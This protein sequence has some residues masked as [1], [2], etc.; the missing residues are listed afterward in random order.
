VAAAAVTLALVALSPTILSTTAGNRLLIAAVNRRISGHLAADH[1]SLGWLSGFTARGLTI[2]DPAGHRV[3]DLPRLDTEVSLL[4]A[5][6]RPTPVGKAYVEVR[7]IDII[8]YP[9]GSS[10]LSRVFGATKAA[11]PARAPRLPFTGDVQFSVARATFAASGG[12][13]VQARNC[14]G[15]VVVAADRLS[16]DMKSLIEAP[17]LEASTLRLH[18][19]ADIDASRGLLVVGE[20]ST[21]EEGQDNRLELAAGT[22]LSWGDEES[23]ATLTLR[24]DLHRL[25]ALLAPV[26]PSTLRV[27]GKHEATLH[28]TG[29]LAEGAGLARLRTLTVAP[30]S[31]AYD[32]IE[33]YGL[34]LSY[35][36]LPVRLARGVLSFGD[37]EL[38]AN[39]GV[40]VLA[41]RIDLNGTEPRYLLEEPRVVVRD[42]DLND[43]L[44]TGPLAFLPVSWGRPAKGAIRGTVTVHLDQASVPLSQ[45]GLMKDGRLAGQLHVAHL[46]ADA[47]AI[48]AMVHALGPVASLAPNVAVRD[49]SMTVPFA[50][51][52]GRV[53][54]DSVAI[55]AAPFKLSFSGSVGL[56]G[57]LVAR[58]MVRVG[59]IATP[60][61]IAITGTVQ[62]PKVALTSGL[63]PGD[64]GKSVEEV[65]GLLEQLLK[66]GKK[67]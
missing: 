64:L 27:A 38:A 13:H 11:P 14:T 20:P 34:T 40:I 18:A 2:D 23:D 62:E 41:G 67:P 54:F 37:A 63:G 58:S 16:A 4:G 49:Q 36:R 57:S 61:T 9:D 51:K 65:P 35:G 19:V 50:L 48:R 24:Y 7:S 28:I 5:L 15:R 12:S 42:V 22:R 59:G 60:A 43:E 66:K 10:S 31:F 44:A 33:M 52:D 47:P 45:A 1:L 3:V 30:V 55:T 56:D 53:Q 39:D 46:N 32:R 17:G 29:K 21:L 26:L 8:S 6:G 25:A